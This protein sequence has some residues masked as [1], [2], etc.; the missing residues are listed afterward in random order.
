MSSVSLGVLEQGL[1]RALSPEQMSAVLQTVK[2]GVS[3]APL[4]VLAPDDLR[5]LAVRPSTANS[6]QGCLKR[7]VASCKQSGVHHVDGHAL[8][9]YVCS[10]PVLPSS[11][12]TYLR[13]IH[14]GLRCLGIP[15]DGSGV[16]LLD[17][18]SYTGVYSPVHSAPPLPENIVTQFLSLQCAALSALFLF[19]V[20]HRT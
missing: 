3:L 20:P 16:K 7:L 14:T 11:A 13:N 19:P 8:V 10:L 17:A 18:I 2:T 4:S 15:V 12:R 6:V 9:K 1:A 5:W